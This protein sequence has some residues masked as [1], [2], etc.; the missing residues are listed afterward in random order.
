MAK[1]RLYT[2]P[3][4]DI[5]ANDDLIFCT[6]QHGDTTTHNV[7][8]NRTAP[9]FGTFD[10]P[11]ESRARSRHHFRRGAISEASGQSFLPLVDGE[12]AA[13]QT[14]LRIRSI[15]DNEI[16][17]IFVPPNHRQSHNSNSPSRIQI[18]RW[19]ELADRI[20][21][22]LLNI[23]N[24]TLQQQINV[25]VAT[26]QSLTT[27][28][29]SQ[30]RPAMEGNGRA[31]QSTPFRNTFRF[32]REGWPTVDPEDSAT[33]RPATI[34][35]SNFV[36][37]DSTLN[38]FQ[39]MDIFAPPPPRRS[40]MDHI[41]DVNVE[42]ARYLQH[43]RNM[44]N[45]TVAA[46]HGGRDV[47]PG[48]LFTLSME[49]SRVSQLMII[50]LSE[51]GETVR[52]QLA[53]ARDSSQDQSSNYDITEAAL[54]TWTDDDDSSSSESGEP[55]GWANIDL[56]PDGDYP[57]EV[58]FHIGNQQFTFPMEVVENW[59]MNARNWDRLEARNAEFI[60][61]DFER[62]TETGTLESIAHR[63]ARPDNVRSRRAIAREA[64]YEDIDDSSEDD[65]DDYEDIEDI[66]DSEDGQA[67]PVSFFSDSDDDMTGTED[68]AEEEEDEEEAEEE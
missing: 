11:S 29:P 46:V 2:T 61:R 54:P 57:Q 27:N 43:I 58:C 37:P 24:S 8:L 14:L 59:M 10:C 64:R 9:I 63:F 55:E 32:G 56:A 28:R 34:P 45:D 51:F 31:G 44:L 12:H 68:E 23:S 49:L 39:S 19:R 7:S 16:E 35:G 5:I 53:A 17:I 18:D 47:P 26:L 15:T 62:F 60:R 22:G 65:E 42:T 38:L 13:A 30:N 33:A 50:L 40:T 25:A 36:V 4:N 67:D 1:H 6:P 20:H 21:R 52:A 3:R 48:R 41:R 66:E